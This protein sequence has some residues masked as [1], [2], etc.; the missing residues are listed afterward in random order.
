MEVGEYNKMAIKILTFHNVMNYG[1]ILQTYSLFETIKKYNT[2]VSIY[3][4]KCETIMEQYCLI[5]T[6]EGFKKLIKSIVLFPQKY[7]LKNAFKVFSK[8]FLE[9]EENYS[10]EDIFIVGSDQ[11]W[12]YKLT[13]FDENYFLDFAQNKYS[14]AASIGLNY[15]EKDIVKRYI[16][17]LK[18]F[19]EV[20]VREKQGK[21]LLEKY[22]D[23]KIRVDLDPIFLFQKEEW[24]QIFKLEN[25]RKKPYVLVYLMHVSDII[26][27][28]AI[29]YAKKHK[30]KIKC[31]TSSI[32][33]IVSGAKHYRWAT[34]NKWLQLFYHA[35][36]IFTN[37]F[38]GIA[39]SIHFN[40]NFYIHLEKE[41]ECTSRIYNIL[42]ICNINETVFLS[43]SG[44]FKQNI[45]NYSD[46]NKIIE[47]ERIDSL[48][49]IKQVVSEN[50][51]S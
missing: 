18:D 19:K 37:S 7:M 50:N 49:Y 35:E 46:I 40:K 44:D 20:S 43:N 39:F 36:C 42:N 29:D 30:L 38:H 15:L 47:K 17:L 16:E 12:N 24:S 3:N 41:N 14:Y 8:H 5:I 2:N 4:Y 51:S 28:A 10:L 23:K 31:I 22:L 13:N 6:K 32:R 1:A 26:V 48:S 9:L 25:K 21:E 11:I 27:N 45:L 33:T 34:P